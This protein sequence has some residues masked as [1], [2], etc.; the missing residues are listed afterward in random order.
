MAFDRELCVGCPIEGKHRPVSPRGPEEARFIVVTEV[1]SQAASKA[2]RLLTDNQMRVF[3]GEMMKQGFQQEDFRFHPACLCAYDETEHT[4]KERTAIKKHCRAHLVAE[5]EDMDPEVIIPLGAEAATAVMGKGTKIGTVKGIVTKAPDFRA[6]VFGLTS[7]AQ[8]V[9]YPQNAPFFKA[10]IQSFARYIGSDFDVEA[11]NRHDAVSNYARI[12][13]LQ[14]LIDQDPDLV[15]FDMETS[16]LR[17]YQPGVDVRSYRPH[18]HKGKAIFKPRFQILTMQFTTEDGKGY[19]L[20]WD[21]PEDPVDEALK[22]KLRNQLRKLLCKPD[23]MVVG[24]NTK[25]DN[26]ALWMTEGIRYR[27]GGDSLMLTAI[28][29]ENAQEKNLDVM[30]KI[31]APEMAGYADAFNQKYDKSRMWEIPLAEMQDYGCGDT[32]AAY[33]VYHALEEKIINDDGLWAHYNNVSIPG[34]NALAGMETRGMHIDEEGAMAEFKEFMTN[35]VEEERVSLL[36]QIDRTLKRE[37]A[38]SYLAKSTNKNKTAAEALKLTRGDFL[39]EVLFYHP[40][41]FKLKPKVFTKTTA[42]LKDES[43]REPSVSAKDHLPYFFDTCPFTMQL[44]EF[45]KSERLL[46][47]SVIKFEENYI[48][49]GKVR[50]IYQLHKTVT[51]RTSSEDP[52]G[53]NYPKRGDRA[54]V[55]RKMF[56]PPPGYYVCE[57]DLSQAELRI[58]ASLSGDKTMIDIYRRAG[59]IHKATALI[60]MGVTMEQ[61][62]QLPK[63]EQKLARTKAKAVNFGFLYGMGWRKFIGYAKTQ[64][65]VDFTDKEAQRI[66]AGFFKLYKALAPWH[67]R[68][69]ETAVKQKYVRSYSGRVRHLPMINSSEE[70]IQQ[71]AIRQAINSPVQEFGSSL[72]VMALGRM[73]ED[74]DP[75][76]LQIVGFIHDAIVVYV[77]KE[78]LDWGMRTV[79]HYMQSNPLEEWFGTKMKVPI[80]ADCGFGENLGDIIECEGFSL[81]EPFNY[82]SLTDKEGNLLIEVPRQRIPP[83]NG[84]LT[85]SAYTTD[86]D[87]EDEN[88]APPKPKKHRI[89]RAVVPEAVVK[90]ILR[91]KKQ[92]VINERNKEAKREAARVIRRARRGANATVD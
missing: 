44:A 48:V 59:D 36:G 15:S 34:L 71:E 5:I 52:N 45:V 33:R 64:Y 53:Q 42:K 91:S 18:L 70:Y 56:V 76:Y 1:P 83:N 47:T 55:Y 38:A 84:K 30:T 6:P 74:I 68:V 85:R 21:H 26:V 54:K 49:G 9:A 66:R 27:I 40:R 62:E 90:R 11:A 8:V 28:V 35:F 50:P 78:Y 65:G 67:E 89:I 19:M 51:G 7:P 24:H 23:R 32:D 60:V 12:Y 61:F 81:D 72:G 29:D 69:R 82:G 92:M 20:V 57:L 58:A 10:D 39:K 14:F 37:V 88:V 4:T 22:P 86:E 41:G 77:K 43:K 63:A 31:Y 3:G 16:G 73:N 46:N 87:L 79:K 2:G 13:D 25:F 75:E 17:W 80:V